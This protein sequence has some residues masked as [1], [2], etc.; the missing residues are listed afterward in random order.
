MKAR[1]GRP[2]R[3]GEFV[4]IALHGH[5]WSGEDDDLLTFF[6]SIPP[7]KRWTAVKAALRAGGMQTVKAAELP[8]DDE[9]AAAVENF[10]R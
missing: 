1:R 8:D 3:T 6:K 7:R 9:L 10:L 4:E 2:R 5:L